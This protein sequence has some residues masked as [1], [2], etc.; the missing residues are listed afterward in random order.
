MIDGKPNPQHPLWRRWANL[1]NQCNNENNHSW[2]YY[3]ARGISYP[4]RWDDFATFVEDVEST[5][6]PLPFKGAHFDRKNND[7]SYSLR[8]IQWS[9]PKENYNNRQTNHMVTY[10]GRKQ[11][12]AEWSR[13]LGIPLRTMWSRLMD[14]GLPPS[15]ALDINYKHKRK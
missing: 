12:L 10:K 14:R 15:K 2:K 11:T 8:N 1:R 5:I 13:E 7:T 3:G 9:S 4:K 6:G